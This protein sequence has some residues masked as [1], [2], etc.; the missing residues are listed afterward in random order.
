MHKIQLILYGVFA[1]STLLWATPLDPML[2]ASA[3]KLPDF[4]SVLVFPIID[5]NFRFQ[6]PQHFAAGMARMG[7]P[8]YYFQVSFRKEQVPGKYRILA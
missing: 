8:V 4:F 1:F 2:P 6:R 3:Y 5:W 7:T